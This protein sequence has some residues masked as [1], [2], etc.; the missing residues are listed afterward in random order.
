M[1]K[2]FREGGRNVQMA[3][4]SFLVF[5][6]ILFNLPRKRYKYHIQAG[7]L[8]FYGTFC[9]KIMVNISK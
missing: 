5:F 3:F 8:S 4:G 6:T 7:S 9:S 2:W 1:N